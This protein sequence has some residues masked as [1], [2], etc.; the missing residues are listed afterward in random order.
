MQRTLKKKIPYWKAHSKAIATV[1]I[2]KDRVFVLSRIANR[3]LQTHQP[4][5][6]VA[7]GHFDSCVN[8]SIMQWRT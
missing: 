5:S 1:Y 6:H 8:I 7:Q 4:E 3:L 2:D